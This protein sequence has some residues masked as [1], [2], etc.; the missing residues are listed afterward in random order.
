M[1]FVAPSSG[2]SAGGLP[3]AQADILAEAVRQVLRIRIEVFAFSTASELVRAVGTS[4]VDIA[5]FNP[6]AYVWA[7]ETSG[8]QVLFKTVTGGMSETRSEI[9]VLAADGPR[10]LREL[11]GKTFGFVDPASPSGY[12]F[13]AAYLVENGV[14]PSQDLAKAVFLGDPIAAVRAV[15]AR[16]VQAAACA[17]GTRDLVRLQ[18]PDIDNLV[19]VIAT[20]PPV[21]GTTVAVRAGL[22]HDLVDR[23]KL[24][25]LTAI[26]GGDGR[27][28]WKSITGADGVIEAQDPDYDFIRRAIEVLGLDVEV[29]A[30]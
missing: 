3:A 22:D 20:T 6:F 7:H 24:A 5:V 8:T 1:G 11:K 10:A 28:A 4:Q 9:I 30:G 29:L 27:L 18:V 23:I 17:E 25:L 13:P 21:P 15:I 16:T 2:P 19:T 14:V 12:L 26:N